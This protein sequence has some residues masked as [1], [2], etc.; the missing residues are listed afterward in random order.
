MD[1]F[2][3]K[4]NGAIVPI[5]FKESYFVSLNVVL[6]HFSDGNADMNL[7]TLMLSDIEF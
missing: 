6:F 7:R 3:I 4:K 2:V 5:S 1:P